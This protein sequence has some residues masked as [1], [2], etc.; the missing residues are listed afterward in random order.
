[1]LLKIKLI[2]IKTS[3]C[4]FVTCYKLQNWKSAK[5]KTHIFKMKIFKCSRKFVSSTV[6]N[7]KNEILIIL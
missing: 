1:M 2:K 6:G 3:V 5:L 7:I 4:T